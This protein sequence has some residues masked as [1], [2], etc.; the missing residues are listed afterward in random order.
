MLVPEIRTS[1]RCVHMLLVVAMYLCPNQYK[2]L[3]IGE[4]FGSVMLQITEPSCEYVWVLF[5]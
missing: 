2:Y 3:V 1:K 4:S 5:S